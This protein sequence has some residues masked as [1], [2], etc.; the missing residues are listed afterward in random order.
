MSDLDAVIQALRAEHAYSVTKHGDWSEYTPD[1][2]MAACMA[3]VRETLV[4]HALNDVS[5]PHG[6][7]VE[8]LQAANCFVKMLVEIG[9][10]QAAEIARGGH[11][12][13]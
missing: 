9:R 12:I 13:P 3:E 1:E 10:R 2:M 6:I 11:G 7:L 8:G 4:A 5:G